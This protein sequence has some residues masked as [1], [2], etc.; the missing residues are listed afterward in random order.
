[1][2][3][4]FWS[5]TILQVLVSSIVLRTDVSGTKSS[6]PPCPSGWIS[7][8]G[9]CYHTENK[10][11]PLQKAE[12][13]CSADGATLF[14]ANSKD[15]FN[16]IT[17]RAPRNFWTWVGLAQFDNQ[18]TPIWQTSSGI[19][20]SALKWLINPFSPAANGWSA[21]SR[22]VAYYN[23]DVES[24]RYLYFYPCESMFYSICERNSTFNNALAQQAGQLSFLH[25]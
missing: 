10:T 12:K 4:R 13:R 3:V 17:R 16:E 9:S 20:P 24:T 22:C 8:L 14:V 1:M 11:M 23:G 5:C 15:E 25:F 19:Q 2:P 6:N 21:A 7:Y 18:A